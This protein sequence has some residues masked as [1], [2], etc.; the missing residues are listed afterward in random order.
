MMI[1]RSRMKNGSIIFFLV[2]WGLSIIVC[3]S[4]YHFDVQYLLQTKVD[5]EDKDLT[6]DSPTRIHNYEQQEQER[7]QEQQQQ[8]QQQEQQQED[9]VSSQK[10]LALLDPRL[11]GGFRN[12]HMR[13][14]GFIIHAISQNISNILLDSLRYD[15][16][17]ARLLLQDDQ[18]HSTHTTTTTI[19]NLGRIPF[20]DLFDVEEWNRVSK[21]VGTHIL[22][23]LVSYN[24]I[25][26]PEWNPQ[27]SLFHVLG[28]QPLERIERN[29]F[30]QIDI[31]PNYM[32]N[33]TKPYAF[34]SG[35]RIGRRTW[36]TYMQYKN[37]HPQELTRTDLALIEA[38]QPS[39]A[40]RDA[41]SSITHSHHNDDGHADDDEKGMLVIHPRTEIEMLQHRCSK[42][43]TRN[44]TKIFQMVQ[45]SWFFSEYNGTTTT[46]TTTT[47]RSK[48]QQVYLCMSRSGL[49]D[50][51]IPIRLKS[52]TDQNLL[53]F[54]HAMSHGLW[55]GTVQVHVGGESFITSL[56]FP[57]DRIQTVAQVMNFFIAVQAKAFIGT[58]GSSYSTDVW[59]TRYGLAQRNK[60]QQRQL[61]EDG[62]DGEDPDPFN[63][64]HGPN[65]IDKVGNGGLPPP[66]RC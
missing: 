17:E 38:L 47:S 46:T 24:P 58:F 11:T 64:F 27:T 1:G 49:V 19:N 63:Y 45:E 23:Q 13:L 54:D 21:R 40:I 37:L 20:E 33:C 36:H 39:K 30:K 60:Q 53:A 8:L 10:T 31:Y 3:R 6:I 12:Q 43:M 61:G 28:T 9:R 32:E 34:G 5:M 41:I 59:T 56:G 18:D 57:V 52:M 51:S 48:Y 26:H 66:H 16:K 4:W 44:L 25:D 7:E 2:L 42:H 50:P 65:G 22:P 55:N 15:D 62:D 35:S 29:S 14:T